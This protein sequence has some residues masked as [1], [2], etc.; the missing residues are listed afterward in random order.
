MA[1]AVTLSNAVRNSL[2]SLEITT[3][4]VDQ[5]QGR[6]STGLR[7]AKATDDPVSF[8]QAK[9]LSDRSFD[10]NEKKAGIDQGISTVETALSGIES[11]ESI[12]RQIKGISTS[13]KS[14]TGTQF[15]DLIVQFNTLRKQMSRI[16]E[17]A[18]FQGV[19]L[20]N[21][22]SVQLAI[23]FGAQTA[24]TLNI[25]AVKIFATA[26]GIGGVRRATD[27]SFNFNRR[28]IFTLS[29]GGIGTVITV[30]Y[31]GTG[32]AITGGGATGSGPT[33]TFGTI[34]LDLGVGTQSDNLSLSPGDVI[35]VTTI[36]S[37]G[38]T[39]FAA[40][41][42]GFFGLY[43]DTQALATSTF[44][45]SS[46]LINGQKFTNFFEEGNSLRVDRAI[47]QLDTALTTL[48]SHAQTLGS[49]VALL[50]TRLDFTE[51]YVKNLDGGAA[52]LTL[53]DINIE[54]VNLLALQTR[55]QLGIS[56]LAFA[57]QAEQAILSLFRFPLII[58]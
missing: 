1:Q 58:L 43:V 20:I 25:D 29:T 22:T 31:Q 3:S 56:S 23:S 47:S 27:T 8:F 7:V 53:A 16:P 2:L 36:N 48:R 52:K 50:Q 28:K 14:A 17:D 41:A 10:F 45:N 38:A 33:L 32:I 12:A 35:K 46:I 55:Q 39:A 40:A 19:N 18:I 5:T 4:L 30:T 57:G 13:L 11:V 15:T 21:G 44:F 26:L 6:L 24:S 9:T 54:G 34:S 42:T 49:N 51:D 37:S